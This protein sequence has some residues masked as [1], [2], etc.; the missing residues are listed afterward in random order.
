MNHDV[1]SQN[2]RPVAPINPQGASSIVLVC[3]HATH[4]IPSIFSDLGLSGD[5]LQSHVAWDP[6]AMAVAEHLSHKLDAT[7]IA[8]VVSR[9]V[10]DCN[11]PPDAPDAMPEKS[12]VH[13]IPGNQNLSPEDKAMRV[14]TCYAPF[15]DCLSK[16]VAQTPNPVMV[17]LHSFTPTYHGEA[18]KVEIGIVHDSDA[19]L[20][21]AMLACAAD[22]TSADLRRNEPYGP[23]HGVTHTL[24]E[25]A[26]PGNHLNVMLEIRNDLIRTHTQQVAMAEMLAGWIADAFGRT[27]AAGSVQCVA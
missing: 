4:Y 5:V 24:R 20:A 23:A 15:R 14:A 1:A 26:L 17:T 10:Y 12:E 7:L 16:T 9:L 19:R 27:N 2:A 11:R 18:R 22:H 21:D 13:V 6:G 25:H 3:E 8:G